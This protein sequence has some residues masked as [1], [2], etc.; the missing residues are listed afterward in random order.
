MKF[1]S[2][3]W[4]LLLLSGPIV[5]GQV[6]QILIGAGDVFIAG[7]HSTHTLAATGVAI[8]FFTPFLIFS[9]GLVMG[10]SSLFSIKIGEG[11]QM[12]NKLFTVI[13]Y[14][15]LVG[16]VLC[17]L[18]LF[19]IDL[20]PL[21]GIEASLIDFTSVFL[22]IIAWSIVP[23]TIFY[24]LKEYLQSSEDVAFA[25][26][27]NLIAVVVNLALNYV[28]VFGFFGNEG[29]GFEGLG[30]IGLPIASLVIRCLLCLALILYIVRKYHWG[31]FEL[32][33]VIEVFKYSLPIAISFTLEILA[34]SMVA[35]LAGTLGVIEAAAGNVVNLISTILFM[36]PLSVSSAVGV[37]VGAAFGNKNNHRVLGN[38]KASYIIIGVYAALSSSLLILIPESFLQLFSSDSEV[39]AMGIS[40]CLIIALFQIF[41]SCHV[42]TAGILRGM[43]ETK[44]P[45]YIVLFAFWVVG[46]P[47]GYYLTFYNDGGL[48]GLWIGLAIGLAIASIALL[49]LLYKHYNKVMVK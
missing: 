10:L 38:I 48:A 3:F 24:G 31:K 17:L 2:T 25:N 33:L 19:S 46:I 35:V 4:Q 42:T 30:E 28:L 41:D 40:V 49:T 34:F 29:F 1:K 6:G 43:G 12:N 20:L 16:L 26:A 5:V 11:K 47:S 18:L 45:S 14:S 15:S 9:I 37:K 39:I 27:I 44:I 13:T 7:L 32:P 36:V 22:E 21:I 8:G 23:A